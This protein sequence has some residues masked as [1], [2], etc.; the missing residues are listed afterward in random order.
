MSDVKVAA[1]TLQTYMSDFKWLTMVGTGR[2]YGKP[3]LFAYV[4]CTERA[5]KKLVPETWEGFPV[6]VVK[7]MI[8]RPLKK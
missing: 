6:E 7:S 8:V 1:E 2:R 3:T 4:D 5:A